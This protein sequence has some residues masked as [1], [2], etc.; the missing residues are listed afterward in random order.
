MTCASL[1]S[2]WP[3]WLFVSGC[4]RVGPKGGWG[5]DPSLGGCLILNVVIE[6]GCPRWLPDVVKPI[7]LES[8]KRN[9]IQSIKGIMIK[10]KKNRMATRGFVFL[11]CKLKDDGF[12]SYPFWY[13][14]CKTKIKWTE[15][16]KSKV[17]VWS[18]EARWAVS[19]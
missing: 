3:E 6:L 8:S 7:K 11:L 4:S 5:Q 13:L 10:K 15:S 17:T 18:F 1:C 9:K 16:N 12:E 14:S 2:I 19:L